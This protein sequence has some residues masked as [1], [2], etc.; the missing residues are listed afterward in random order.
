MTRRHVRNPLDVRHLAWLF[1][2]LYPHGAFRQLITT[3][4]KESMP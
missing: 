4:E 2:L 1:I 3:S